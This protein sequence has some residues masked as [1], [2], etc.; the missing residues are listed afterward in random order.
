MM[1]ASRQRTADRPTITRRQLLQST[2]AAGAGL[3]ILPSGVFAGPNPPSNKL[4]VAVIGAW[5]RARAHF[6]SIKGEN[7]VA[8]CDVNEQN[9]AKGAETFPDAKHYV[10][11]RKCLEQKNIDAVVCST[12]DHTHAFI[13][14]WALNR[15]MHVYCE[16]PLANTVEEARVVRANWLSKKDKLATQVGTQ[17]HAH[18]NFDRVREMILDGAV[19][20]LQHVHAWGNR[21]IRRPGYLPPAGDPPSH[22]HYDLWIGPSPMHPYN[23]GYFGGCLAWNMYWDFGSGQIGDMGSHTM[24]L[25]WYGIDATLPTTAE[26][27]GGEFNPEVTPVDM[28]STFDH[29][30]NDW[31]PPIKLTW[32]QG[33][34][35]AKAKEMDPHGNGHGAL[36]V[37][38][39]A[40]LAAGFGNHKL[41]PLEKG[42]SLDHYTPRPESERIP[43]MG[44]FQEQWVKAC[45]GDLKCACDFKYSGDAIE[46][47]LLGLVAYRVG[48]K[49]EYDS[50]AG[51]VTNC[52]EA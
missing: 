47:M 37:G 18:P 52:D 4:N 16:K 8:L 5:G 46:Q 28:T 10:D 3:A 38:D 25:A 39:K 9:L 27:F 32:Y 42:G 11:W 34:H 19:G 36:F 35:G 1:N 45:K 29:P 17:R 15:D 14:N 23:P 40:K 7:V 22:L 12:T 13:A 50:K 43:F 2:M 49:L 41:V 51:R 33:A 21:E 30:A 26:A 6:N 20:T 24:D 44:G 48:K 31:R